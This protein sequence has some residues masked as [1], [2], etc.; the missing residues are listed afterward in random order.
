[1]VVDN[2]SAMSLVIK[3]GLFEKLDRIVDKFSVNYTTIWTICY[4][5]S[6]LKET[7]DG[8]DEIPEVHK[9]IDICFA[10]LSLEPIF[11]DKFLVIKALK[12]LVIHSDL[13]EY[14]R[15]KDYFEILLVFIK[16]PIQQEKCCIASLDIIR[17]CICL[18]DDSDEYFLNLDIL[19]IFVH[20]IEKKKIVDRRNTLGL[21]IEISNSLMCSKVPCT[22]ELILES[23]IIQTLLNLFSENLDEKIQ[24]E[25]LEFFRVFVLS[26]DLQTLFE[27]VKGHMGFLD[28]ILKNLRKK[29]FKENNIICMLILNKI[30]GAEAANFE[31]RNFRDYMLSS[32][33]LEN[34]EMMQAHK[35]LDVYNLSLKIIEEYFESE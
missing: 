23:G 31:I 5:V 34:L 29:G 17:K 12:K 6:K 33:Y 21:M 2:K 32:M 35:D 3:R 24:T 27:F 7:I 30:L 19:E 8:K 13:V 1:M 10:I 14:M 9:F 16:D 15:S 25:I 28:L 20:L 18:N 4:L 26:S 22:K 11:K